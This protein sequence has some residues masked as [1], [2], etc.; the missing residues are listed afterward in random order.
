[1]KKNEN[2]NKMLKQLVLEST[3]EILSEHKKSKSIKEGFK[4]N[5]DD[6][7]SLTIED[8]KQMLRSISG[9][10]KYKKALRSEHNFVEVAKDLSEIAD[11]VRTITLAE[12]DDEF[13]KITIERNM[14]DL[15]NMSKSFNKYATEAQSLRQRLEA[16]YEDMGMIINRY[17]DISEE[18]MPPLTEAKKGESAEGKSKPTSGLEKTKKTKTHTDSKKTSEPKS[19]AVTPEAPSKSTVANA[20]PT[21]VDNEVKTMKD[22]K[23]E[24][25]DKG[26]KFKTTC[27][28]VELEVNGMSLAP[29][30]HL[31]LMGQIR[32]SLEGKGTVVKSVKVDMATP[33]ELKE[34][35]IRSKVRKIL[36]EM[37]KNGRQ[38]K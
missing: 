9:Y 17:Y 18:E 19:T 6:V 26:D 12:A 8:K 38:G 22:K 27:L 4:L 20:E 36:K 31:Y 2:F 5:R 29:V 35:I 34:N 37:H 21:P 33:E 15:E 11:F 25:E 32:K 28:G 14:K 13:D 10:N 16:L 23:D 30:N 24:T 1:M 7:P 3:R